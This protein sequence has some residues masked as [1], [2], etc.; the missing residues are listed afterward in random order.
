MTDSQQ[1]KARLLVAE[2]SLRNATQRRDQARTMVNVRNAETPKRTKTGLDVVKADQQSSSGDAALVGPFDFD[3]MAR[4]SAM[5]QKQRLQ[6]NMLFG[7]N[8]MRNFMTKQHDSQWELSQ[9]AQK[10]FDNWVVSSR[11]REE[12]RAT[13]VG[14]QGQGDL[15]GVD[16]MGLKDCIM[17]SPTRSSARISM[18]FCL[19][20]TPSIV[21]V[22]LMPLHLGPLRLDPVTSDEIMAAEHLSSQQ[23]R[24][25]E[26]VLFYPF[27]PIISPVN[28]VWAIMDPLPTAGNPPR[29]PLLFFVVKLGHAKQR[30]ANDPYF[31][32][33]TT[34]T[35]ALSDESALCRVWRTSLIAREDQLP[36]PTR[37]E[38]GQ[39]KHSKL[40][41]G[42]ENTSST[43]A[44]DDIHTRTG[45]QTGPII[46]ESTSTIC[47][48]ITETITKSPSSPRS[49]LAVAE[50][51]LA[52]T[53][54]SAIR[55]WRCT[56][57]L[58]F[59]I[60]VIRL[61][62]RWRDAYPERK[63]PAATSKLNAATLLTV[64]LAAILAAILI[65]STALASPTSETHQMNEPLDL[66][67]CLVESQDWYGNKIKDQSKDKK[68]QLGHR[69]P[70]SSFYWLVS[71]V[72][73]SM[74][75][76]WASSQPSLDGAAMFAQKPM[77]CFPSYW[78]MFAIQ[79]TRWLIAEQAIKQLRRMLSG[80][81]PLLLI[82]ITRLALPEANFI[83]LMT[84]STSE[85]I[86]RAIR[87]VGGRVGQND[88]EPMRC[89]WQLDPVPS[90]IL[91]RISN[92]S[93]GAA[94]S[95][96]I[97]VCLP[98]RVVS[99]I[100]GLETSGRDQPR[101]LHDPTSS[102]ADVYEPKTQPQREPEATNKNSERVEDE[103]KYSSHH[104][105]LLAV[106]IVHMHVNIKNRSA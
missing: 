20:S 66:G 73:S 27:R 31:P 74:S 52:S 4:R 29:K 60:G 17:L 1:L 14:D 86:D 92:G 94:R 100:I 53:T 56:A 47:A 77:R 63:T 8:S 24:A 35:I 64:I 59:Y 55:A 18:F 42:N 90:E 98:A 40:G 97:R 79:V 39:G 12:S 23:W 54:T 49:L 76:I 88:K 46:I 9:K 34:A 16:L 96:K 89:F 84:P 36:D 78:D 69:K 65:A 85:D 61:R 2:T 51:L 22:V 70:T 13:P 72:V 95:A 67:V 99:S 81:P 25:E 41:P 7:L 28:L 104:P 48:T 11:S 30:F 102:D 93:K 37:H 71:Q 15:G 83:S 50:S 19:S 57:N 45:T 38:Y 6:S 87:S 5:E 82:C 58:A 44:K 62:V 101:Q 21:S 3:E 33:Y 106:K 80:P 105:S 68:R 103:A 26:A 91:Q 32:D 75:A 43:T 10:G